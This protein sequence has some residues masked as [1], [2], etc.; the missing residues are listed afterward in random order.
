MQTRQVSRR[1][2]WLSL[3]NLPCPYPPLSRHPR[4]VL[5]QSSCGVSFDAKASY[6]LSRKASCHAAEFAARLRNVPGFPRLGRCIV[7]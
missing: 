6:A 3:V 7:R 1:V 2:L 4:T 5:R